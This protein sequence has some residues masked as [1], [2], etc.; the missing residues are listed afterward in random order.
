[1]KKFDE[2]EFLKLVENKMDMVV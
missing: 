1:L 2:E